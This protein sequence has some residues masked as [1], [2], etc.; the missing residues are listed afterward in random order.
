MFRSGALIPAR[1]AGRWTSSEPR[2]E[3]RAARG[4]N[5]ADP[6]QQI[7]DLFDLGGEDRHEGARRLR[8]AVLATDV[9]S[10]G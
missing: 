3:P 1:S 7:W 2:R 8:A 9:A 10:A 6:V 5:L 4:L